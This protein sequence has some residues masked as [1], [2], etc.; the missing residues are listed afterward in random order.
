[1]E[2]YQVGLVCLCTVSLVP[3]VTG[4]MVGRW[5]ERRLKRLGWPAAIVPGFVLKL[6]EDFK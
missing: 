4:F 5:F 6:L 2:N 1:M 3:L